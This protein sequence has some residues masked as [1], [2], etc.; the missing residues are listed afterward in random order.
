MELTKDQQA[1]I[2][3]LTELVKTTGKQFNSASEQLRALQLFVTQ[4]EKEF[5]GLFNKLQGY[6]EALGL[7]K[8]DV[9]FN[10]PIPDTPPE[11]KD[12]EKKPKKL[13]VE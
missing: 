7:E 2:D 11:I 3:E 6:A 4:K 10:E 1:K 13:E 8:I 9:D 5:L 12:K